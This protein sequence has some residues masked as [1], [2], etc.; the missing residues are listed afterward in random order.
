M[1]KVLLF[2]IVGLII[3]SCNEKTVY[4]FPKGFWDF[5]P[6]EV[7]NQFLFTNGKDTATMTIGYYNKFSGGGCHYESNGFSI[8][9]N[10]SKPLQECILKSLP[11]FNSNWVNDAQSLFVF[12]N[13][14]FSFIID[15]S[16]GF[17]KYSIRDVHL[18]SNVDIDSYGNIAKLSTWEIETPHAIYVFIKDKGITEIRLADGVV[19]TLIE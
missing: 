2:A 14:T 19:W 8:I 13:F 10:F 12:D 4:D 6:Y 9:C 17:C 15:Y 11:L 16:N 7:G 5:F 18:Y 3:S 1:K